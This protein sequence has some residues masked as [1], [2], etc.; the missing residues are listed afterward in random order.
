MVI[1]API[2]RFKKSNLKIYIVACI[3]FAVVFGYDGYLSKYPWSYRQGFYNK[4]VKDG[5][6]D[7][8]MMFQRISPFF[9]A[10]LAI[11][12]FCYLVA[13]KNKKIVADDEKLIIDGKTDIAY[14][15]I[16]KVDKTHFDKKG[17][18][19]IGYKDAGD[20][21]KQLKLSSRRYDNLKPVLE[22][23]VGEIS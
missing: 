4:H 20:T 10:A 18:F 2:S 12:L 8:T 15:S 7:D 9:F 19:L 6:P 16:Q 3:I 22:K 5:K 21:E 23:I 14:S 1:E 11:G 13:V 17:F